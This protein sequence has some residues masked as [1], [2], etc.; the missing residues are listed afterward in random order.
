[1]SYFADLT[2]HKYTEKKIEDGVLNI[3]WLGEGN[4]FPTG[5]VPAQFIAKLERLCSNPVF[6]HR[7]FHE[8]ELCCSWDDDKWKD[9]GNGQIRVY[10]SNGHWY[11]APTMIHHYVT[12]HQY[13]PP[14]E[15]IDAVLNP[16]L[17]ADPKLENDYATWESD[18][19]AVFPDWKTESAYDRWKAL[20]STLQLGESVAGRVIARTPLSAWLDICLGIPALLLHTNVHPS[21]GLFRIGH[22]QSKGKLLRCT[23]T[24]IGPDCEIS[25][26]YNPHRRRWNGR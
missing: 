1:M 10:G 19:R 12:D 26:E 13:R 3:G 20:K 17:V 18:I 23:I 8:C 24:A 6:L 2:S 15:F 25:L 9:L 16:I 14:E 5:D 4:E 11:S 7:G 22:L 21:V